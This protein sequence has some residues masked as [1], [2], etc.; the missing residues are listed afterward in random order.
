MDVGKSINPAIDIGQI[1]GGFIQG[2]GLFCL[3]QLKVCSS[4]ELFIFIL[5]LL[6]SRH[7]GIFIL[8]IYYKQSYILKYEYVYIPARGTRVSQSESLR[9]ISNSKGLCV[10]N[11][12]ERTTTDSRTRRLQDP[13][14]PQ[15]TAGVQRHT[16]EGFTQCQSC[17]LIQG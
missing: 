16:T 8:Y 4:D 14:I 3:E 11:E 10:G 5:T 1:E 17:L 9:Y 13:W 7:R 12:K 2:Y 6:V 15:H